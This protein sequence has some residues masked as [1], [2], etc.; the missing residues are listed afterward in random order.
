MDKAVTEVSDLNQLMANIGGPM[1]SRQRL[2]MMLMLLANG[3]IVKALAK[4][5]DGELYGWRLSS[6]LFL[7]RL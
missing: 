6:A 2:L 4:R 5:E 3:Y 7:N 1:S